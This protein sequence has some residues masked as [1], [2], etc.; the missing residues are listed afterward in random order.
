MS[1]L[2]HDRPLLK[3]EI[4]FLAFSKIQHITTS[5]SADESKIRIQVVTYWLKVF[6]YNKKVIHF[7]LN[8]VN[9][10]FKSVIK[11]MQNVHL[12]VALTFRSYCVNRYA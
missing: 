1:F 10:L 2:A 9:F 5:H 4:K 6:S 11:M 3:T 8:T 7:Y 12:K